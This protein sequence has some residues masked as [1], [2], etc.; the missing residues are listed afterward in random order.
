MLSMLRMKSALR[1]TTMMRPKKSLEADKEEEEE[2]GEEKTLMQFVS[3]VRSF[4]SQYGGYRAENSA[5][6]VC[7]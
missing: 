5:Y 7:D 3:K 4:S 2:G 1:Q 6:R